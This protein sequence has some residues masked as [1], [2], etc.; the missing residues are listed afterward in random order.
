[1]DATQ[2]IPQEHLKVEVWPDRNGMGG[3]YVGT[4]FRGVKVTHLPTDTV[5]IS[6]IA[7]SQHANKAIAM[8][9]ILAAI[10]HPQFR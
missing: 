4:V 10:T 1:M 8:E 9:M 6:T 3:Q 2:L 5:A 7:R